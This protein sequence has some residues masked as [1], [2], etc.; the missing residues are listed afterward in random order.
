MIENGKFEI[1]KDFILRDRESFQLSGDINDSF[2]AVRKDVLEHI[3]NKVIKQL[4]DKYN[5]ALTLDKIGFAKN[6]YSVHLKIN[7]DYYILVTIYNYFNGY[8]G[9]PEIQFSFIT[10][11]YD[12]NLS[13]LVQLRDKL[14]GEYKKGFKT[15]SYAIAQW[16]HDL[17]ILPGI[18]NYEKLYDVY[19][20]ND[21]LDKLTSSFIEIA[22]DKI[23]Y[24][25]NLINN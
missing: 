24:I 23:V 16:S 19:E 9:K 14:E 2:E 25:F 17:D 5:I 12:P 21:L 20:E 13:K 10:G 11:G 22:G 1:I 7:K 15:V 4:T 8:F 18:D 3:Y 6:Y